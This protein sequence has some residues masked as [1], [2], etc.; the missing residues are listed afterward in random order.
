MYE[1]STT[2][3]ESVTGGLLGKSAAAVAIVDAVYEFYQGYSDH[4]R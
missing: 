4:R 3:A 1:I 2:E